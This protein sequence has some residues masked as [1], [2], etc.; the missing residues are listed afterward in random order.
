LEGYIK[1]S[2][3]FASQTGTA[4]DFARK[5]ATEA[6]RYKFHAEVHDLEMYDKVSAKRK[7]ISNVIKHKNDAI[8]S[9]SCHYLSFILNI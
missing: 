1:M 3:F 7:I 5:L 6:K 2:I 4:E 8:E 9:I